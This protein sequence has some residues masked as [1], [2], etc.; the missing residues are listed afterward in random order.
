MYTFLIVLFVLVCILMS[1]V[2]LI[3]SSKGGGLAGTFGGTGDQ[4]GQVFGGRGA[5][6]FLTKLTTIL[7][8]VF[9]LVALLLGMMTRGEVSESSLIQQEREQ[10]MEA[11]TRILPQVPEQPSESQ[12]PN[13]APTGTPS[14]Q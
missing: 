4:M 13:P 3:Q 8:T 5:G 6:D 7:A 10:R 14:G 1:F 2:I 11:P 9:M 12:T